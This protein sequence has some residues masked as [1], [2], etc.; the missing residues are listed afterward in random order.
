MNLERIKDLTGIAQ[1]LL[2]SLAVVIGG[3]WTIFMFWTERPDRKAERE[4][5]ARPIINVEV[6]A[7]QIDMD[8][9]GG[10]Y[11]FAVAK[12]KNHGNLT[13]V[14]D[15]KATPPFRISRIAFSG[16][17]IAVGELQAPIAARNVTGTT[18]AALGA[19]AY[20]EY[21]VFVRVAEPGHYYVEFLAPLAESDFKVD[22][23]LPLDAKNWWGATR[24]EVKK[25]DTTPPAR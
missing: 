17:R 13:G 23:L 15:L 7:E 20:D 5:F 6:S 14:I 22:K 16:E 18:S 24:L 21:H 9:K 2:I 8:D 25:R 3:G 1:N 10:L 12:L 4:A 11:V 19:Q